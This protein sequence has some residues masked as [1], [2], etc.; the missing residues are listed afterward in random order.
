[1]SDNQPLILVSND[2]GV[3]AKGLASLIEAIKPF[4]KIVVVAPEQGESGMSHAITMK[5][6]L[7]IRTVKKEDNLEIYAINGTPVDSVKIAINRL[8]ERTPDLLLSGINH[9]SNASVSVIYS[10]TLGATREGCLNGIPS[11][12]FSL[13]NHDADA[14]FSAVT[15]FIPQIVKQVLKNGLAD[16]TFL[17]VNVPDIPLKEIKG[18][19]VCKTT[20]G[21]WKEIYEHRIDP[22]GGD[23]FW[24]TGTF[25]N[26]EPDNEETDE[27]ALKNNYISLV[28]TQIDTTSYEEL[29]DLKKWDW[30]E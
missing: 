18:I 11:I 24:L 1:M 21:V 30:N 9:G 28:P 26:F 16:Q 25:N 19:K 5:R 8:L 27:W 17:N 10:G 29:E 4:G 7:R 23:Y 12:G 22:N 20:K 14:N 6:P 3:R 15:H 2:D 13:L